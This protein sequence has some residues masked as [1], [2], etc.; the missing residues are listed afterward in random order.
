MVEGDTGEDRHICTHINFYKNFNFCNKCV[1]LHFY[2]DHVLLIFRNAVDLYPSCISS[3]ITFLVFVLI[4]L[5]VIFIFYVEIIWS[6]NANFLFPPF[7]FLTVPAN[8]GIRYHTLPLTVGRMPTG[9]FRWV[10]RVPL[11]S[12]Y[13]LVFTKRCAIWWWWPDFSHQKLNNIINK[14]YLCKGILSR[15]DKWTSV[16]TSAWV[17]ITISA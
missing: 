3:H 14:L 8:N 5:W 15:K 13:K 16:S 11:S 17:I 2:T 1:L 6:T 4:S 9:V 7:F 10:V 12:L